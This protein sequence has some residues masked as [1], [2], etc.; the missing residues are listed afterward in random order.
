ME[1]QRAKN[2]KTFIE[3][4]KRQKREKKN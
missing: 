4:K 2:Q 3:R 1:Q